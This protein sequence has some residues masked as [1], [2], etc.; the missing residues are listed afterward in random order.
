TSE[1]LDSPIAL[2]DNPVA[3]TVGIKTTKRKV[4]PKQLPIFYDLDLNHLGQRTVDILVELRK[5]DTSKFPNAASLMLRAVLELAVDEVHEKRGWKI[6]NT[7]FKNRVK[8]CLH[9]IDPTDKAVRFRG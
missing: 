1:R 3:N 4:N 8:K 7:E 6:G 2:D 9:E 5:I